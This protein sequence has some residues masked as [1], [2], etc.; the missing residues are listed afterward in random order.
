VVSGPSPTTQDPPWPPRDLL[1][2]EIHPLRQSCH[3]RAPAASDL[4]T[5]LSPF[6][7]DMLKIFSA[8]F[9]ELLLMWENRG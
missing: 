8:W 9:I 5:S 7:S 2:F 4:V 6:F 3:Q 1:I